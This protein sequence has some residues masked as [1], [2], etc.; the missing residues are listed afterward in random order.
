MC[1]TSEESAMASTHMDDTKFIWNALMGL[2]ASSTGLIITPPPMPQ[3]APA[4]VAKS[5]T[6][7]NTAGI[8][9]VHFAL[10]KAVELSRLPGVELFYISLAVGELFGVCEH[11]LFHAVN[12]VSPGA[13]IQHRLHRP[14]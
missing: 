8:S 4:H 6:I 13:F 9:G 10:A 7:T 1:F 11:R 5:M 3:V 12:G 14:L 2:S